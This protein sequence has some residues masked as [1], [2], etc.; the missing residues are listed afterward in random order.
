MNNIIIGLTGRFGAGSTTTYD[1]LT[2]EY[3][4]FKGFSL[5]SYLKDIANEDKTY[6][7][8]SEKEKRVYL[9]NLGDKLR[10]ENGETFIAEEIIKKIEESNK[11]GIDVVVDSFKNPAEIKIFRKKYSNFYLFAI[12]AD[13]EE[14]WE[15]T[16][17]IYD[18]DRKAFDRDDERDKG[19]DDE[20][21]HGQQ[22]QACIRLSDILINSDKS[23]YELDG[24]VNR[25]AVEEYGQKIKSHIDLIKK[26]G[27]RTP[28]TDEMYMHLAY[29]IALESRCIK[30]QVGAIIVLDDDN[31]VDNMSYI[32][33]TGYNSVPN[34][35]IDCEECYRDFEIN[36]ILSDIKYCPNC[37]EEILCK[38][39]NCKKCGHYFYKPKLL[40]ICRAVHAEENAI[41]QAAKLGI[42]LNGTKLYTSTHPCLLCSKKIINSGIKSIVYLESYPMIQAVMM[43]EKCKINRKKYEG[44]NSRAYNRLFLKEI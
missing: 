28:K 6:K 7:T 35:E 11:K 27:T 40:D 22:V 12:D 26:P 2:T 41:L 16:K 14:R 43:L 36:K 13:T 33:T 20:P 37:G 15:R 9:Q 30:R 4:S 5:S 39:I 17:H 44:V 10:E 3:D 34:G 32:L 8:L 19:T 29:S 18:L 23:F 21:Y 1:L 31:E 38:D 25:K 24:K 42:S